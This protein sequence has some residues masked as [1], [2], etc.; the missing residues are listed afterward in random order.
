MKL[1][2][3]INLLC[4]KVMYGMI[5]FY[6]FFYLKA[7]NKSNEIFQ[8][9]LFKLHKEFLLLKDSICMHRFLIKLSAYLY[10]FDNFVLLCFEL[11]FEYFIFIQ[12]I[13][14]LLLKRLYFILFL[15]HILG[16]SFLKKENCIVLILQNIKYI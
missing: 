4:K 6:I 8:K 10:V 1:S 9:C 5:K 12:K 11:L 13:L 2:Q 14:S 16:Y 3:Y 7:K 15:L